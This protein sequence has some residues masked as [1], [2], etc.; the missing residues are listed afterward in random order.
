MFFRLFCIALC[1]ATACACRREAIRVYLAPKDP[2]AQ[3]DAS[4]PAPTSRPRLT[5]NLPPG[6][7]QTDPGEVSVA[8]FV[9]KSSSGDASINITPMPNLAGREAMVV[10]MW[11]EQLHQPPLREDEIDAALT[12]VQVGN[13][14]GHLFELTHE[15][16][17]IVTAMVHRPEGSWFF[18]LAG[19]PAAVAAKK[20]EFLAFLKSIEFPDASANAPAAES[21]TGS[22]H[23]NVPAGWEKAAPGQMQVAKFV[24]AGSGEKK[25]EVTVSIFPS[26]TGGTLANV[27]RWRKQ[28]GLD[29]LD[30]GGLK[31][32]VSSLDPDTPDAILADLA[33]ESGRRLLGAIVPRG[34]QWF[35]YKMLG[36]AETVAQHR[37]S[38]IAFA[39]SPP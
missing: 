20:P 18:K 17:R 3:N 29:P 24:V 21:P 25:S 31:A 4:P 9:V 22:F 28:I 26:D 16:R 15:K 35:F 14:N 30:E 11:R 34:G 32:N 2:V 7:Q 27:N 10:N 36:D 39:K 1:L 33:N 23:W 13:D 5:W 8:N 19:D 12:P 37:D 38:F 6:W